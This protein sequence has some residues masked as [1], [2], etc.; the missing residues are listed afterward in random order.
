VWLP[1]LV[2]AAPFLYLG[3]ELLLT[4][5]DITIFGDDALIDLGVLD[6]LRADQPLGVYS[7]FG[8]RHPGPALF[9]AAAPVVWVTGSAPWSIFLAAQVIHLVSAVAL[10]EV[11]RRR[12]GWLAAMFASTVVLLYTLVLGFGILRS[13]WNPLVVLLPMA[14]LLVL[15]GTTPRFGPGSAAAV[16]VGTFLVQANVGTALAVGVLMAVAVVWWSLRL[17]GDAR[18]GGAGL[19][20]TFAAGFHRR[21]ATWSVLALVA[22]AALWVPPL[23]EQ[24]ANGSEGNMAR[25]LRS[26]RGGEATYGASP[27]LLDAAATVG[28]E[29]LV[30]P[31][32]VPFGRSAQM[33]LTPAS[34][35]RTWGLVGLAAVVAL[36]L[37]LVVVGRRRGDDTVLQLGAVTLVGVVVAVVALD[38]VFAGV[39]WYLAVWATAL[40]VPLLVGCGALVISVARGRV[41]AALPVVLSVLALGVGTVAVVQAATAPDWEAMPHPGSPEDAQDW[42]RPVVDAAWAAVGPEVRGAD[43]VRIRGHDGIWWAIAAGL[44]VEMERD[45]QRVSV[46]DEVVPLFGEQRRSTGDEDVTVVLATDGTKD[47]PPGTPVLTTLDGVP[48]YIAPD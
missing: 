16:L 13:P 35:D 11:V 18:S 4:R 47:I 42:A 12:A 33:M 30:L 10:V 22:A 28:R 48:V 19:Q 14:L 32:G 26:T 38:R 40:V 5:P 9:V 8:F 29:A 15:L 3:V 20:R 46:D 44:A 17:I 25:L 1:A 7:R 45:G 27:G 24:L 41:A 23:V 36:A 34:L 31:F 39:H 6:V 37:S 21:S 43:R 2:V